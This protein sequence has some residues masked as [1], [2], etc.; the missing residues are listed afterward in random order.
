MKIE[1]I[2]FY[3]D[4]KYKPKCSLSGTM[5]IRLPELE[6]DIRGVIVKKTEKGMIFNI[7][8]RVDIFKDQ[9]IMYPIFSFTDPT[10]QKQLQQEIRK[11]AKEYFRK[12]KENGN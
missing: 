5:H 3:A 10:K 1:I 11:C 8:C 7:P 12:E 9:K 4:E 2:A 6:L